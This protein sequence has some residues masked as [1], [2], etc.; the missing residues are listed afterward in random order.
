MKFGPNV[1]KAKGFNKDTEY[2]IRLLCF[3]CRTTQEV[4]ILKG[5]SVKVTIERGKECSYC[6]CKIALDGE[7][8]IPYSFW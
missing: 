1:E 5:T 6:G 7:G 8:K 2:K 4:A 3:N